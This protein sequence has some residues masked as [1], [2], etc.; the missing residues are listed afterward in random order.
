MTWRVLKFGGT[1]VGSPA[2]LAAACEIVRTAA[3]SARVVVVASALSGVTSAIESLIE[4][5]LAGDPCWRQGF[6]FLRERHRQQLSMVAPGRAGEMAVEPIEIW[7]ALLH[8]L[9]RSVEAVGAVPPRTRDLAL[10]TGERLSA[11]IFAAALSDADV[12]A[13]PLDGTEVLVAEGPFGDAQPEV[14]NSRAGLD[15]SLAILGNRI[16]VVTGFF[17]ADA[18]GDVKIF[19]RG[20][21]DTSAAAIG[22]ALDAARVEIWTDVNGVAREDPRRVPTTEFLRHL[23]YDEAEQLARQ[24][25]KVLHW[26]A[27]SPARAAGVPLVV[28]NTLRPQEVGTWIGAGVDRLSA[29]PPSRPWPR[30]LI[31]T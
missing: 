16:A 4:T 31:S 5:A 21:S 11:T 2:A 14:R 29:L 19:G 27:V 24:G 26:K 17:G 3:R 22:A 30:L 1:S 18:A 20:G 28:R 12:P 13:E 10:A 15:R 8:Y 25:A 7:L 6:R 9:L 23:S